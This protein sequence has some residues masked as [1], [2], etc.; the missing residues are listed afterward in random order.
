MIFSASLNSTRQKLTAA[1]K[2]NEE[3]ELQIQSLEKQ[4]SELKEGQTISER[5]IQE[6]QEKE[7]EVPA[8]P[9]DERAAQLKLLK[10]K[11]MEAQ[12]LLNQKTENGGQN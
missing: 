9:F 2:K 12:Q 5:R 6:L 11:A 7:R 1:Q 4:I 10:Q 8:A 3:L